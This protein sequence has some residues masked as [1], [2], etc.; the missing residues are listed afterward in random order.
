M[1]AKTDEHSCG[2]QQ[3]IEWEALHGVA[4]AVGLLDEARHPALQT[5]DD[6]LQFELV[7]VPKMSF[8]K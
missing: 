4:V 2:K 8:R 1:A 6:I 5:K 3:A 7:S